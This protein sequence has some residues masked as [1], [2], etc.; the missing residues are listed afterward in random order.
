MAVINA[1]STLMERGWS[2]RRIAR[3][4]GINRETVSR[5]V[6]LWKTEAKPAG[7]APTGSKDS[8]PASNAPIGSIEE[9]SSGP[10]SHCEVYRQI[11]EQKVEQGL[12]RQRI[13]QDLRDEYGS[14]V[15]YHSVRRFVNHL[16]K[17][18]PIPFR[19]LE[20]RPG[21][22]AQVDFGTG[23][24]VI[25]QDGK[26]KKT[27][28]IRVVLSFS[29]KSYSETVFQQTTDNF[30]RCLENAFWHFGGVVETLV[31]DNLAAAVKRADWYDPDIHPKIQSFCR[32]YG[33]VI[34]PCKPYTP[35]HKGKVEKG[36]DYVKS[37]ALKGRKFKSLSEQNQFLLNWEMRIADT[38]IHGT[39]RQ[40]VGKLFREQEKPA[41]LK[42]PVGRFPSFA[43]AKR[44][45]HRDGHIE[46][47][48]AYYSVAPEYTGRQ[49]WARWDGHL[50][51][52]FNSKMEQIEVYAKGQPGTFHTRAKHIAPQKRTKMEKGTVWLLQRASLIG[53]NVDRWA[54]QMLSARGIPGIRVLVGLLN[55]A[56]TYERSQIDNA[57]EIALSHNAFRLKTIRSIIKQGGKKQEQMAFIDEHPII[58]DM[59]SYGEFVREVLR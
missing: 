57:C 29:R 4:L 34:L 32:H 8:K 7:N 52:I 45:V 37:N 46:V 5:Y 26:R 25:T 54:Q 20:C 1:I 18:S 50:V 28:V 51:R 55:L 2:Q 33:T 48:K 9:R 58:R 15:S 13:W 3:E 41:L 42:L 11:I 47:E 43:E 44:S 53:A 35:R 14:D 30:I 19:R 39:T 59:S 56:N 24:P 23:A 16:G 21:E 38:R 12:S 17:N 36:I 22:Q 6:H 49:V 10:I 27:H 40:Q 31:I